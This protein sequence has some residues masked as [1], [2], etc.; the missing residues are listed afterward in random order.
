MYTVQFN[1]FEQEQ[2][3]GKIALLC[4]GNEA[5]MEQPAQHPFSRLRLEGLFMAERLQYGSRAKLS[6]L[7]TNHFN[8]V[9]NGGL[10]SPTS[11]ERIPGR[12]IDPSLVGAFLDAAI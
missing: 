9:S 12:V 4:S 2:L 5:I 11:P 6:P 8:G 3:L 1:G 7:S 10:I